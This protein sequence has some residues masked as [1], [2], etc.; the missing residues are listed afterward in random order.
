MLLSADG[1]DALGAGGRVGALAPPIS[2]DPALPTDVFTA[3]VR[4]VL[5]QTS[6]GSAH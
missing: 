5:A 6:T 4:E 2:S 3:V 1:S